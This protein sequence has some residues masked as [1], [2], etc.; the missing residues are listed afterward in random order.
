MTLGNDSF[1]YL[2]NIFRIRLEIIQKIDTIGR[3][4]YEINIYYFL[5]TNS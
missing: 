4:N 5:M 3:N 2:F 1:G